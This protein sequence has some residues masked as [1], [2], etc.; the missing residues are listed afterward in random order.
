MTK[1]ELLYAIAKW[2]K[3]NINDI[4]LEDWSVSNSNAK[5]ELRSILEKANCENIFIDSQKVMPNAHT[6][7]EIPHNLKLSR[8]KWDGNKL[9][10]EYEEQ[11]NGFDE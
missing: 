5:K 2:A 10:F 7:I 3:N 8:A 9:I 1:G 4:D 6:S 11:Y